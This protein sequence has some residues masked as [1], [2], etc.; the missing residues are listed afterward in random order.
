MAPLVGRASTEQRHQMEDTRATHNGN[1]QLL[2]ALHQNRHRGKENERTGFVEEQSAIALGWE[3]KSTP[4]PRRGVAPV[5]VTD[6]D[7]TSAMPAVGFPW[8]FPAS[9]VTVR[10]AG[11]GALRQSLQRGMRHYKCRHCRPARSQA[12]ISPGAPTT[13][14]L[15]GEL[16]TVSTEGAEARGDLVAGDP[17]NRLH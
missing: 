3:E 14:G 7:K 2:S 8:R 15:V 16:N 6:V 1:P 13:T 9:T 5:G 11:R 4:P 10:R 12:E 17:P